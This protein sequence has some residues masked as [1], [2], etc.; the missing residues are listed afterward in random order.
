MGQAGDAFDELAR[1]LRIPPCPR[2]LADFSAEAG[3]D[4]PD[5]RVL[6]RLIA[7]DAGLSAAIL[8][9]VNSP[10]FGLSRQAGDVAQALTILGLR[11]ATQLITSLL[12]RQAFPSA[13]GALMQR[14][15]DDSLRTA[16]AAM[17][18]ASQVRGTSRA[19]AHAFALFRDCGLAVMIAR[20]PDYGDVMDAHAREPGPALLAAE[21][22]RYRFHHA[23][24]GFALARGWHLPDAVCHA[25]LFHH[26]IGAVAA[27]SGEAGRADARLVA[28]GLAA[29]QVAN[30]RQGAGLTSEWLTHEAWVLETLGLPAEDLAALV[31]PA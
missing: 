8:K 3:R 22:T 29:E 2:I 16:D 6:V 11:A 10:L 27:R 15:W 5:S 28:L 4:D 21:E 24:V 14:Y 12:L 30:L 18:L 19:E 31:A 23:R 17:T 25:I 20:F 9:A 1:D 26:D 7:S 13:A